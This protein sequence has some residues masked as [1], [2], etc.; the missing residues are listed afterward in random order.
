VDRDPALGTRNLITEE[1]FQLRKARLVANS[2]PDN[3]EATNF[4]I[5]ADVTMNSRQASL[6]VD[7]PNGRRPPNT[8]AA[9]APAPAHHSFLPGPFNSVADFGTLDRCIAFSTVPASAPG[10]PLEIVQGPGYIAI[11]AEWIHEAQIVPLNG[12]PHVS[13]NIRTY[14]GDSRGHWDGRTLVVE[15]SNFN[16]GTNLTGNAGG[17]PTDQIR[18]TERFTLIDPNTLWYEAT[19]DDPGTWTQPW[20]LAF[21]RKREPTGALYEYACHEGNYGLANILRASRAAELG[22]MQ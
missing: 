11:R 22:A 16:G 20:T 15:T 19:I 14:A 1:E 21:P 9:N 3:I 8:A 17:R 18:V 12:S 5:P 13:P 10:N 6:V 7:P 2:S 4:G